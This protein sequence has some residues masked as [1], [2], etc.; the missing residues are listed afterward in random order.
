M[1]N[2]RRWVALGVVGMMGVAG[3]ELAVDFDRT[4]IDSGTFDASISETSTDAPVGMDA[5]GDGTVADSAADAQDA[6]T[7]T[8]VDDA[9]DGATPVDASD[10]SDAG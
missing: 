9:N 5:T 3:C 1:N 2:V 7:D 10:A 4:R 6:A 8:A